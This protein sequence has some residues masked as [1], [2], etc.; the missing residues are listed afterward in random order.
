MKVRVGFHSLMSIS[1]ARCVHRSTR[2]GDGESRRVLVGKPTIT[3]VGRQ[4]RFTLF[5][6]GDTD[7]PHLY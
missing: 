3:Q 1:R 5:G 7:F 6:R 4:V 2:T